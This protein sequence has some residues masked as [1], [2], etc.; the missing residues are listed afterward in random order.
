MN[1]RQRRGAMLMLL[2]GVGAVAVFVAM[3]SYV[4]AVRAEVGDFRTVLQLNR[5]VKANAS[6]TESMVDE[7]QVPK[8]W[9]GG[10][11]ITDTDDLDGK[12]AVKDLSK[13][14]YLN[15]GMVTNAPQLQEGQRE[16]AILIDA[17]TGVAGKVTP[18][19]LVDI[20]ATF[21]NA[22]GGKKACA[23]PVL[24]NARV[25]NVGSLTSERE[26]DERGQV[27]T[28]AVV[29]IT[30]AL[31]PKEALTLT[32]AES[33]SNKLRLARVGPGEATSEPN[34]PVCDQ[35]NGAQGGSGS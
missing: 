5:D 11:F 32:Y 21:T 29:P 22:Q 15:G 18:G 27:D 17:E 24:L 34:E 16:I 33:F 4:S 2:A 1:P 23:N 10:T 20:Y 26:A 12:V 8:K 31:S 19:S 6:I 35:P 25:V 14:A 30:F 13:G 3:L 28:K 7:K 9:L